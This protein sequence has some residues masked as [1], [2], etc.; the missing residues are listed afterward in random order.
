ML[1]HDVRSNLLA[2][3]G[4]FFRLS[5]FT[6]LTLRHEQRVVQSNPSANASRKPQKLRNFSRIAI[7]N[8]VWQ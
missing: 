8:P 5:C 1:G 6:V 4:G 3:D 2:V 7:F